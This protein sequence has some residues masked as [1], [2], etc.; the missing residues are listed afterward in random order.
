MELMNCYNYNQYFV[1]MMN[2]INAARLNPPAKGHK[3]HIIPKCCFKMNKLP[4]DNSKDNLVLLTY[5]D[6]LKIHKLAYMCASTAEFKGK[7]AYAY[8][9]LSRGELVAN[10]CFKGNLNAFFGKHHTADTCKK[11]SKSNKGKL[12]GDKNPS[13]RIAVR[14]KLKNKALLRS[15]NVEY[16]NKLSNV[17]KS[18]YKIIREDGTWYWGH[19]NEQVGK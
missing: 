1:A 17:A 18:R 14:D 4:V 8:Q 5:E 12:L 6:H 15:T 9:R 11:I 16:K 2:I 7:M 13:K 10:D 3:H 19:K